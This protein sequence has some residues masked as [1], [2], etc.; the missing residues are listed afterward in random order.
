[1]H[2]D[3]GMK[4]ISR[5]VEAGVPVA[6]ASWLQESESGQWFLYLITPLVGNGGKR[7]AYRRV[8]AV[9]RQIPPP[10]S[11]DSQDIKVVGPDS[12]TGK[13]IQKLQEGLLVPTPFR[14]GG[15]RFGDV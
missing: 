3:D 10:F 11:I 6:A 5:L 7:D 9:I 8:N 15:I 2:V 1:M 4:L 14:F 13:A 12:P